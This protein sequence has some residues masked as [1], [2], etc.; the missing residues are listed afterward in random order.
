MPFQS[1]TYQSPIYRNFRNIDS[2]E[3][4]RIVRFYERHEKEILKLEFE[5][6]IELLVAYTQAL[7]DQA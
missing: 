4:R 2:G 5:E 6:Y 7:F 3:Y 1:Q